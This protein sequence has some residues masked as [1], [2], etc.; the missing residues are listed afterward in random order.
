M[1]SLT[2]LSMTS[3]SLP[4]P[5][6]SLRLE[7]YPKPD[8]VIW[9]KE[10]FRKRRNPND[11]STLLKHLAD[12]MICDH[13]DEDLSNDFFEEWPSSDSSTLLMSLVLETMSG[14]SFMRLQDLQKAAPDMSLP[15]KAQAS[16]P[17]VQSPQ[18]PVISMIQGS[19][20]SWQVRKRESLISS[21]ERTMRDTIP[22]STDSDSEKNKQQSGAQLHWS[23]IDS[24]KAE[25]E[26]FTMKKKKIYFQKSPL[27][28]PKESESWTH[29]L[30]QMTALKSLKSDQSGDPTTKTTSGLLIGGPMPRYTLQ[31]KPETSMMIMSHHLQPMKKA[32]GVEALSPQMPALY[33]AVREWREKESGEEVMKPEELG[34]PDLTNSLLLE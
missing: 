9:M 11:P 32:P 28:K 20:T 2:S 12:V 31:M 8:L 27:I 14:T 23:I 24:I 30:T 18:P 10:I 19:L 3:L 33:S 17:P 6:S 26:T 15:K 16:Q 21:S 25:R 7:L 4:E 13:E 34:L 22:Y 1:S 5:P 29:H